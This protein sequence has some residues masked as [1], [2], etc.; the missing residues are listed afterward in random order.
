MN[1]IYNYIS[2]RQLLFV[3]ILKE[4][5]L[6]VCFE[7][8]ISFKIAAEELS[9][10]GVEVIAHDVA[11][12]REKKMGSFLSVTK[13]TDEPPVFLEMIYHPKN[14]SNAKPVALVGTDSFFFILLFIR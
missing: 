12:I 14:A 10:F 1:T 13:A 5:I 4:N 6:S 2:C 7:C 9:P 11:W 8:Q 3:K